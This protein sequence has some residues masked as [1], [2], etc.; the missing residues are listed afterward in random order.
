VAQ[1]PFMDLTTARQDPEDLAHFAVTDLVARIRG[2]KYI[3]ETYLTPATL[4]VRS[5]TAKPRQEST[6]R[7]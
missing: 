4:I 7:V 5:S 3:S 6:L 1:F 2:E